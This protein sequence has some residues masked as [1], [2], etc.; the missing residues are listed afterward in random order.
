MH[1]LEAQQLFNQGSWLTRNYV[2]YKHNG[3]YVFR[4]IHIYI[5]FNILLSYLNAA[6]SAVLGSRMMLLS[7]CG[8][9][10]RE[11]KN[12]ALAGS[13]ATFQSRQLAYSELFT[14]KTM[15]F[16]YSH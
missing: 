10:E 13:I 3:R 4:L 12:N 16:I 9:D 11:G 1:F 5:Y 6:H 8:K 15:A 14:I 7:G 2:L